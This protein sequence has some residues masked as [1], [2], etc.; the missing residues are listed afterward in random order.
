MRSEYMVD[1]FKCRACG[2]EIKLGGTAMRFQSLLICGQC[3]DNGMW[4]E[5]V[6]SPNTGSKVLQ[7]AKV[8]RPQGIKS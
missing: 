8:R 3:Y 2:R 6:E 1:D 5:V 4:V 7:P